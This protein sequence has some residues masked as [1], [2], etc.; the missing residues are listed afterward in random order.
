MFQ[1]RRCCL[2]PFFST[3]CCFYS[4]RL[5]YYGT[6]SFSW[7]CRQCGSLSASCFKKWHTLLFL[8][9]FC[10]PF[11][12]SLYFSSLIFSSTLQY[13]FNLLFLSLCLPSCH[14]ISCSI[15]MFSQAHISPCLPVSYLCVTLFRSISLSPPFTAFPLSASL[16]SVLLSSDPFNSLHPLE[17]FLSLLLSHSWSNRIL[18]LYQLNHLNLTEGERSKLIVFLT[19]SVSCN[20]IN[21][22]PRSNKRVRVG[23]KK[24]KMEKALVQWGI[25]RSHQWNLPQSLFCISC[26]CRK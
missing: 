24:R 16:L 14:C 3:L 6:F 25:M 12:A 5:L 22:S 23:K 1:F 15:T 8:S 2:F 11:F 19:Q 10:P 20:L 4:I 13:T 26:S 21:L 18:L 7:Y 17:P 9:F